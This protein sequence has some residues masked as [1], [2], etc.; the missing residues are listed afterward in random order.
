MKNKSIMAI[1]VLCC[2]FNSAKAQTNNIYAEFLGVGLLGSL[3]YERMVRDNIF[4]RV[5]YGGFSIESTNEEWDY[6]DGYTEVTTKTS[7]NPLSLGAHYLRGN[8]WKL[9]AGAGISYWMISFEGSADLGG[10]VGGLS[11]SADGGFLMFYTSFGFRYQNPEGGLNFKAGVS[12]IL[13]SVDGES[14]TLPWPHLS[15][16]YS[17]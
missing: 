3:N 17:F 5:S 9:E 14:A 1:I 6:Y 12:P 7:I 11:V 10:D 13:A 15:L 4:A 8:K 2:S 16:G